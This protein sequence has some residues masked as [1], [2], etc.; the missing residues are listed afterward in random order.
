MGKIVQ[1]VKEKGGSTVI[2]ADHGN[3]ERMWDFE[4]NMPHT[5]HT[6]GDVPFIIVDEE[7][8]NRKMASGGR[9]SDV[10]PTFLEMMGVPKPEEM[11]GRSLLL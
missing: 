10:V 8:K 9:L 2:L 1:K 7:F 11:T 4:N 5:A 6:V 3:F